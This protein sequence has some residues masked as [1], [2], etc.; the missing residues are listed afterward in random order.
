M[1]EPGASVALGLSLPNRGVLFGAIT[2]EQILTLSELADRSEVFDSVWVGDSLLAKPRLEAVTTLAAIAARTRRVRLGTCCM[3]SFVYRHP[4]VFAIQWAS[5]DVLSGG[6]TIFAACMGASGGQGM[7]AAAREV[8][9]LQFRP[10]ERVGRFEE[11]LTVVRRLWN[12]E[13]VTHRGTYYAFEDVRLEPRPVQRPLPVWIANDPDLRRPAVAERQCRRVAALAD[14]WMTDGGPTPE[15]F[16]A[17]WAL[18]ARCLGEAGRSPEGFPAAYH[19]MLNIDDD[20]RRAWDDGVAFLTKYYGAMPEAFLRI[21]LA[22]GPPEEVARRIQAYI[23]AGCTVPILRFAAHD[24]P[25]QVRRFI[26]EVHPR[27]RLHP[28]HPTG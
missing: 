28:S 13:R 8:R 16:A 6:R 18:V 3:A 10:K 9:A 24:A 11:G 19:M 5:L 25:E 12:E 27:L 7:G 2:V 4:I 23:D 21:W 22:A 17:R 15:V 26:E 14:G 20:P 1:G